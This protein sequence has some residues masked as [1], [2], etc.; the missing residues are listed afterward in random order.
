MSEIYQEKFERRRHSYRGPEI[1]MRE[2]VEV[3]LDPDRFTA[4]AMQ[5][6]LAE[7][8]AIAEAEGI[9]N[10]YL[11]VLADRIFKEK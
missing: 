9:S 8:Y 6:K 3:V 11:K 5:A 10:E 2:S 1:A 7:L 4:D